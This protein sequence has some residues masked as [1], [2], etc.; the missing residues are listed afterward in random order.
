[1]AKQKSV[2]WSVDLQ[3]SSSALV[4]LPLVL[5]TDRPAL[6]F[7]DFPSERLTGEAETLVSGLRPGTDSN[8]SWQPIKHTSNRPEEKH[9]QFSLEKNTILSL[10]E[11]MILLEEENIN[12]L[13]ITK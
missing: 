7:R 1:M 3:E 10:M 4:V 13:E 9:F 2:S 11:N 6:T 8:R 5:R 12:V